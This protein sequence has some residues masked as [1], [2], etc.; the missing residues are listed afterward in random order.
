MDVSAFIGS[1]A[2]ENYCMGFCSDEEKIEVENYAALYPEVAMEL[3]SIQAIFEEYLLANSVEPSQ[4]V[5]LSVM[6]S[7]YHVQAKKNPAYLPLVKPE[8]APVLMQ[9][10]IKNNTITDPGTEFT[11]L[12]VQELPST[13]FITNFIVW[14]KEG[15]E[16]EEHDDFIEYLY[17]VKGSCTMYYSETCVDFKAGEVICIPPH[18]P[19]R[20]MVTSDYPMVAI[21]QRQ[22]C[23]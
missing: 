18:I 22:A 11:N 14:A 21:V 12:F 9:Q 2:L 20:A 6:E 1:G 8:D 4:K 15:H 3:Q 16:V 17:I 19:H 5:K 7:I 13:P 10:W 23:A